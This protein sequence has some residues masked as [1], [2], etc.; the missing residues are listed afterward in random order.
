MSSLPFSTPW[1][2]AVVAAHAEAQSRK[3]K[4]A[5]ETLRTIITNKLP[6]DKCNAQQR[7]LVRLF[8]LRSIEPR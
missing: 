6:E 4:R 3:D 1:Q 7:Q 5:T 2:Q 8:F